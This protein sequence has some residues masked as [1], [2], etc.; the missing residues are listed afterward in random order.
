[1]RLIIKNTIED[2]RAAIEHEFNYVIEKG[3]VAFDILKMILYISPWIACLLQ[4]NVIISME[5][6]YIITC[7]LFAVIIDLLFYFILK[8]SYPIRWLINFLL[9]RVKINKFSLCDKILE[10]N[11]DYIKIYN[12]YKEIIFNKKN[13]ID[14]IILQECLLIIS[15][16]SNNIKQN[17]LISNKSFKDND[18]INQFINSIKKR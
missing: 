11:E 7:I 4:W 5:Y 3:K 14:I 13:K 10:I 2:Y 12:E 6:Y 8:N 1:M 9:I 16:D 15:K 17:I 18:E